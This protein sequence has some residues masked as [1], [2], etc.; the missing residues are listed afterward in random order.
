MAPSVSNKAGYTAT[1]IADCWI[2]AEN[3]EKQLVT[4]GWMD[5]RTFLSFLPVFLLSLFPFRG[6]GGCWSTKKLSD[7]QIFFRIGLRLQ[8][9]LQVFDKGIEIVGVMLQQFRFFEDLFYAF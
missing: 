4:D 5:G 7:G 2:G 9:Y 3:L 8:S 6:G 1:E